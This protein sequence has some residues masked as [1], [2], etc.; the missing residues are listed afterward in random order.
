M[1]LDP[2]RQQLGKVGVFSRHPYFREAEQATIL[3]AA[4]EEVGFPT[5]WIPGFDGGEIFER[6]G[7]GLEATSR[8]TIATGVVNIWRHEPAEVAQMVSG[9]RAD[10]GGR[11]LLGVGSSHKRLIGDDY[12]NISPMAKM[13]GYLDELDA[14]GQRAE[15]RLLGALGPKML[16][17]SAQRSAGSHPYFVPVE[18]TAAAREILGDE[19]LLMPELTVILESD[20]GEARVIARKF[21]KLYLGMP[22]YT[23]NLR[24]H[25]YTD[26][27]LSG[28]GSD[29]LIDSVFAWGD[30]ETIAA[31]VRE[32]LDAGADHV[33][34]QSFG[35]KP[36]VDVWRELAPALSSSAGLKLPLESNFLA[37]D[38]LIVGLRHRLVSR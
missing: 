24:R 15:D 13:K 5:L 1:K 38:R 19:P 37:G 7:L 2:V 12:D 16:E 14:A 21:I 36:E 33:A 27:D 8:L 9:L 4:A 3:A 6:C 34:I 10:S 22:N 26:D 17:L 23:N 28:T 29:R 20:P 11:F 32:H 18:H 30:A 25:G 35:P 31:R